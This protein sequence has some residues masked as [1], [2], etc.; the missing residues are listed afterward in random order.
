[1]ENQFIEALRVA[2][3]LEVKR[4]TRLMDVYVMTV[5]R[6]NAPRLQQ[7][8]ERGRGGGVRG[9]FRVKGA[10]MITVVDR[11]E[12]ALARPVLDETKLEGF[13]TVDMKWEMS[14]AD[15]L[16]FKMDERFWKTLETNPKADLLASLPQDLRQGESLNNIELLMAEL[17]KSEGQQLLPNPV[18]V[19]AAAR[20]CLGLELTPTKR[21]IEVM[22]V[23]KKQFSINN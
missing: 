7:D 23:R 22:Q 11:L 19:I 3:N 15:L 20:N 10:S 1:M 12:D 2:F 5:Q 16:V 8:G 6:T 4:A 9:G 14:A 21:A 17:A 13:F 18:A